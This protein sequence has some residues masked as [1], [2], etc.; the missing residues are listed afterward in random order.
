MLDLHTGR[1][2]GQAGR[3]A[4]TTASCALLLLTLTGVFV[5]LRSKLRRR[6][7]PVPHATIRFRGIQASRGRISL[8]DLELHQRQTGL[9]HL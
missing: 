4:V 2:V 7:M 9:D 6:N 5:W 8:D 1:I 3:Y